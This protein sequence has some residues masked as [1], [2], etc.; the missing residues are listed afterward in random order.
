M[1]KGQLRN[2]V[3]SH[4]WDIISV[5]KKIWRRPKHY[6]MSLSQKRQSLQKARMS[7][8]ASSRSGFLLEIRTTKW[9]VSQS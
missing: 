8:P 7:I 4:F 6:L 9:V 2:S 3:F 5:Y 1:A